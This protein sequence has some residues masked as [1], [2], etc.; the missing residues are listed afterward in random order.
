ME[1]ALETMYKDITKFSYCSFDRIVIRGHVPVLQG[2]DGGGVV[3]W[4]RSLDPDVVL[5]KSW[6]ESFSAKFHINVKKYADEHSIPILSL[7]AD[8]DKNEIAKQYLPKD[9]NFV[10]V[11]LIIKS[12]EMAY[13]FASQASIQN[14]NPRHRNITRE[15]RCI[16]HFHFYLV[17][18]Y[19]GPIS[20]RFSSHLPC[21]VKV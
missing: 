19:W 12:R 5:T 20:F 10:G 14:K 15:N 16:D 2:K 1:F 6:F 11:Y 17:D 13:S 4:A 8:Q 3:Y 9:Q 18:K 21:N 7:K